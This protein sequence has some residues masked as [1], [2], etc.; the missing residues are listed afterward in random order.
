MFSCTFTACFLCC[1]ARSVSSACPNGRVLHGHT[2]T[3]RHQHRPRLRATE[4]QALVRHV[5]EILKDIRYTT[6]ELCALRGGTADFRY[7]RQ[8]LP[9]ADSATSVGDRSS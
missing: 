9:V 6:L 2:A 1:A 3:S 8:P 4:Q 5:R 7:R